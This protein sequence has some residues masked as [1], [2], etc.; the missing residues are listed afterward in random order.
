MSLKSII[1]EFSSASSYGRF[2]EQEVEADKAPRVWQ[3]EGLLRTLSLVSDKFICRWTNPRSPDSPGSKG[4]LLVPCY[5]AQQ[6]VPW[7][8]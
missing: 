5:D 6:I 4:L 3:T 7:G 2:A 1:A 8:A